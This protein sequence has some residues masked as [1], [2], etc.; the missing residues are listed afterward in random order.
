MSSIPNLDRE[1]SPPSQLRDRKKK[2]ALTNG[3]RD[4][5]E[6]LTASSPEE[7]PQKDAVTWGRTPDGTSNPPTIVETS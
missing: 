5:E 4:Q 1:A 2:K 6:T 3:D 7:D